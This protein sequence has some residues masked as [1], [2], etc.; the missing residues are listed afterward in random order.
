MPRL[1]DE[2]GRPRHPAVT[3]LRS[4]MSYDDFFIDERWVRRAVA[5]YYALVSFLDD[6]IGKVL[7]AL[8]AAGLTRRPGWSTPPITATISAAGDSAG[9]R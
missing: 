6:N 7:A 2:A 9:N 5:S 1:Y 4:V 8:E 3:A